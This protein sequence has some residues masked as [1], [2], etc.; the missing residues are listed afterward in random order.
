[1]SIS[2]I[3]KAE[4]GSFFF[5]M[6]LHALYLRRHRATKNDGHKLPKLDYLISCS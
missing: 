4:E 3:G 5:F 1:M 2:M 6:Y